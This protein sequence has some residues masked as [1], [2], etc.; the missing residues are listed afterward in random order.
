MALPIQTNIKYH[1]LKG[2]SIQSKFLVYKKYNLMQNTINK[3][4]D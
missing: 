4:Q 1:I 2:F 3:C